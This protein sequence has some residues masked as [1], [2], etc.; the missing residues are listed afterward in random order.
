MKAPNQLG[1]FYALI[2]SMH[3]TRRVKTVCL[4]HSQNPITNKTPTEYTKNQS[5]FQ[6][7]VTSQ[8][9]INLFP[10]LMRPR[11]RKTNKFNCVMVII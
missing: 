7:K 2:Q 5:Y 4:F 10:E 1:S 9:F 6:V 3:P 8:L 11:D